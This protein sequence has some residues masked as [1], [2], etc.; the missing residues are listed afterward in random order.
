MR[1]LRGQKQSGSIFEKTGTSEGK[2]VTPKSDFEKA[3]S[4]NEQ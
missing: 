3:V 1:K 4:V 2:S